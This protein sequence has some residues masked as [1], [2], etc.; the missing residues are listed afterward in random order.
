V[1][2]PHLADL[3]DPAGQPAP[4]PNDQKVTH[5]DLNEVIQKCFEA[6]RDYDYFYLRTILRTTQEEQLQRILSTKRNDRRYQGQT[7]LHYVCDQIIDK[8]LE[9]FPLLLQKV[10]ANGINASDDDNQTPLHR[11]AYHNCVWACE[12]LLSHRANI[13]AVDK[14]QLTPLH[15]A[16][17][18]GRADCVA[19]LLAHGANIEAVDNDQKTPLHLAA[20]GGRADCVACLLAHKANIGAADKRQQTPLHRAAFN[21]HAACVACLL[22]HGA[23]IDAVDEAQK[24]PLHLAALTEHAACVACLLAHGA[25]IDAVDEDQ[26]TPLHWATMASWDKKFPIAVAEVLLSW[27]RGHGKSGDD[28]LA[29]LRSEE[30]LRGRFKPWR[31][32]LRAETAKAGEIRE[33]LKDYGVDVD[34]L[35]ADLLPQAATE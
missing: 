3:F 16:A 19:C 18:N 25:K 21:G 22:A 13:E 6:V 28:I 17:S 29:M 9:I 2:P 31:D 14:D 33:L 1:T 15:W 27:L 5:N 23:K 34:Q 8:R 12:L 7:L 30:F 11:A 24:T 20:F 26:L 10:D 4:V 35:L 32:D